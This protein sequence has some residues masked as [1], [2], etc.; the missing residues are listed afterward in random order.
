MK[1]TSDWLFYVL[2]CK[3]DSLYAGITTD[4]TRRL[5]EHNNTKRGA[6][7]TRSRR[8]VALVFWLDVSCRSTASK[9]ESKFKKLS[10]RQKEILIR[11]AGELT[12]EQLEQVRGGMSS[13][14]FSDWRAEVLNEGR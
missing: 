9:I 11:S 7:Y 2:R 10:R 8:P 5:H 4:I 13:P 3:D 14:T 12:D 1:T 6:K